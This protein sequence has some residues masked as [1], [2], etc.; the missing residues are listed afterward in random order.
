MI[1]DD[2]N[3]EIKIIL[4]GESGTGKSNLINICCNLNFNKNNVPNYSTSILDKKVV[5]IIF[6]IISNFGI[7][8]VKKNFVR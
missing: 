4:L 7:Q 3:K 5:L 6:N 2:E 8:P 1:Y